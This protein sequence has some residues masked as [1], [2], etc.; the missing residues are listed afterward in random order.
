M[1]SNRG[2]Q[3]GSQGG[4]QRGF[5]G[6]DDN[7]QREI[8]SQGGKA[9]ARVQA[10]DADGQFA[11]TEFRGN[12]GR[13]G[14]APPAPTWPARVEQI[15]QAH[16]PPIAGGLH[17]PHKGVEIGSRVGFGPVRGETCGAKRDSH[18]GPGNR[19]RA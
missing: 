12:P 9:S 16:A 2:N 11:G 13:R 4:N 14:T 18:D 8:A 7:R 17:D 3:G 6:M 19:C 1:A 5:A 15:T 10:R